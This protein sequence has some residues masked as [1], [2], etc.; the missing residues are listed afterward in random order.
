VIKI[1]EDRKVFPIEFVETVRKSI[2]GVSSAIDQVR[3]CLL[4]ASVVE[5]IF[6]LNKVNSAIPSEL[7]AS[8]TDTKSKVLTCYT[9]FS[10]KVL[11]LLSLILLLG[12]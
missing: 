9:C 2:L 1:W 4:N 12:L 5:I 11:M 10:R 7:L 3:S 8:A 6:T